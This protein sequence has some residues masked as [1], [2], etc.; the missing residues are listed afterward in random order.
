MVD[1]KTGEPRTAHT[2]N[3]VKC[4][5]FGNSE[6]KALQNGKLSDVA[7]TTLELLGISKPPEMTGKSLLVKE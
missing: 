6:V 7:P 1:P 2:S 4:I 5:Y 3:P